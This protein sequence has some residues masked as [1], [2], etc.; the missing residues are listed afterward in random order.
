VGISYE[1][2][3][4]YCEYLKEA[5]NKNKVFKNN[6]V[7]EVRLPTRAEWIRAARGDH[8]LAPYHWGGYYL[9]NAKGCILANFNA[10]GSEQ[11]T[12]DREKNEYVLVDKTKRYVWECC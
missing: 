2:A 8:H 10:V 4:L 1:A 3:L 12:F 9:R 6:E 11:I 7:D 5:L